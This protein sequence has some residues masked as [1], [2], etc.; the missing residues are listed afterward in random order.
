MS[1]TCDWC[2]GI[3][4]WSTFMDGQTLCPTCLKQSPKSMREANK[5]IKELVDALLPFANR[6]IRSGEILFTD[7]ETAIGMVKKYESK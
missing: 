7:I 6:N 4:L 1:K 2:E 3:G 5:I